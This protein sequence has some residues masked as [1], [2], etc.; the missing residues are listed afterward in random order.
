MG[1]SAALGTSL[2]GHTADSSI[3]EEAA[4]A[5]AIPSARTS[6]KARQEHPQQPL[7]SW[8]CSARF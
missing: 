3:R 6:S 5:S 4:G 1:V 8:A 2:I 7:P